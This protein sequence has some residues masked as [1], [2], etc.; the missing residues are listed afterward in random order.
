MR[1]SLL[2]RHLLRSRRQRL[3]WLLFLAVLAVAVY[4]LVIEPGRLV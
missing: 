4:G 3:A 1:R 2:L